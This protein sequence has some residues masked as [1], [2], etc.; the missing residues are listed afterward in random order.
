MNWGRV[1]DRGRVGWIVVQIWH[2]PIKNIKD[3]DLHIS[4]ENIK[5]NFD[6]EEFI[7][8]GYCWRKVFFP[9][10]ENVDQRKKNL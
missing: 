10:E 5:K 3:A 2:C 6:R 9:K 1:K 8:N 4:K 7:L